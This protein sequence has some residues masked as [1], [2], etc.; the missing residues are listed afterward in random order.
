MEV[1]EV[2]D[3]WLWILCDSF[4]LFVAISFLLHESKWG[5]IQLPKFPEWYVHAFEWFTGQ[6]NY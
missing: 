6:N 4:I 1:L 2:E 3:E 5:K